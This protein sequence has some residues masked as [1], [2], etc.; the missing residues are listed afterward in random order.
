M[1]SIPAFSASL[2]QM[3]DGGQCSIA[4]SAHSAEALE[5]R[6]GEAVAVMQRRVAAN[7]AKVLDAAGVFEDRQRSVYANAVRVLGRAL[8]RPDL[9]AQADAL[10]AAHLPSEEAAHADSGGT[11]HPQADS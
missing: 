3:L 4:I 9:I 2:V 6:L 8:E 7:N 11:V 1:A 10:V 5:A